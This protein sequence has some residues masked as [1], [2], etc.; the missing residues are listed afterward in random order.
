MARR[1]YKKGPRKPKKKITYRGQ[2]FASK[3]EVI[4]AQ[5]CDKL[6]IP[7]MYEPEKWDWVPPIKKYT[8]DFKIMRKDGSFFYVEFKGYFRSEDKTKMIAIKKQYP[9]LDVRFVFADASKPVEGAKPRKDGTKL[10][11][12]EWCERYGYLWA[13]K[14]M[15][16]EWLKC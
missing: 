1:F 10:S 13:D 14:F 3:A 11:N 4:F 9:H 2:K 6:K 12:A 7:W 5:Q 15:P 16:D 8:P